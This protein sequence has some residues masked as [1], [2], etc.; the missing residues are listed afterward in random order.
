MWFFFFTSVLAAA[1]TH[2]DPF[3]GGH[4]VH[5]VTGSQDACVLQVDL[6]TSGIDARAT[7]AGEKGRTLGSF[8]SLVGAAAAVNGDFFGSGFGT[9]GPSMHAGN[10]WGGA[11]HTYVAPISFGSHFVDI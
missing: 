3:A 1:D 11:D 7:G 2:S 5:R 4:L 6:C 9:D 8:S 10:G